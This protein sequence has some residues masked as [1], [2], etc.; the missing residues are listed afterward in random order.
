VAAR[1]AAQT[2]I[3][4]Y[5]ATGIRLEGDFTRQRAVEIAESAGP[6]P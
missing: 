4:Q 2:L 3:W 6:R 1:L 5:D